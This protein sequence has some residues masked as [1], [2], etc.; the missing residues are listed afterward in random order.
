M[1]RVIQILLTLATLALLFVF[2]SH[3]AKAESGTWV[4]KDDQTVQVPCPSQAA[5]DD[6]TMTLRLPSGCRVL[7]PRIGYTVAQDLKVREE[8]TTLRARGEL[9]TLELRASRE[10]GDKNLTEAG[11]VLSDTRLRLQTETDG[12]H[13]AELAL[14]LEREQALALREKVTE[15]T[16]LGLSLGACLGAAAMAALV[17][18]I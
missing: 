9:L 16:V 17:L 2:L 1:N 6:E 14:T 12:R 11:K 7:H 13:E 15:R 3:H 8:L 10:A 18:A 5:H 4:L